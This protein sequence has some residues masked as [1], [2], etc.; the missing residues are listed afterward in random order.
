MERDAQLRRLALQKLDERAFETVRLDT[1][2]QIKDGL[3]KGNLNSF[4]SLS[5]LSQTSRSHANVRVS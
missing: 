3:V 5:G 1:I 4:K 2:G